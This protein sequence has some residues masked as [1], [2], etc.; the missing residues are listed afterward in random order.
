MVCVVGVIWDHK[1]KQK[2]LI[3]LALSKRPDDVHVSTCG[4]ERR[5]I[6]ITYYISPLAEGWDATERMSCFTDIPP[7]V[8]IFSETE[9]DKSGKAQKF[10]KIKKLSAVSCGM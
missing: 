4:V 7:H 1:K 9:R 8:I 3:F 2:T 10:H 6:E 5:R